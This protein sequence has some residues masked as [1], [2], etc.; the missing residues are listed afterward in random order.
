MVGPVSRELP[1]DAEAKTSLA[2]LLGDLYLLAAQFRNGNGAVSSAIGLLDEFSKSGSTASFPSLK[3][4]IDALL[5]ELKRVNSSKT[6]DEGMKTAISAGYIEVAVK[7]LGS[8]F[9]V[10]A[11]ASSQEFFESKM[12]S[13]YGAIDWKGFQPSL[14]CFSASMNAWLNAK[15][16]EGGLTLFDDSHREFN[17][18]IDGRKLLIQD[19]EKHVTVLLDFS[20]ATPKVLHSGELI[21]G[22]GGFG[23]APGKNGNPYGPLVTDEGDYY[24][25]RM[26]KPA[27][28]VFDI[29]IDRNTGSRGTV[30]HN[31]SGDATHGCYGSR[32]FADLTGEL[33][34]NYVF[35]YAYHPDYT[36]DSELVTSNAWEKKGWL[37]MIAPKRE[38]EF[39]SN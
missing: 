3:S 12:K 23:F 25:K 27:R 19:M 33:G 26:K 36:S 34:N 32:D 35:M 37:A 11:S 4:S 24:S 5:S 18:K 6:Y 17:A 30:I 16:K 1:L 14:E 31:T 10:A 22:R 20:G 21:T 39:A 28:R 15:G 38:N 29:D 8:K 9:G 13:I 2:N 7:E